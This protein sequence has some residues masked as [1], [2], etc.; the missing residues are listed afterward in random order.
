MPSLYDVNFNQQ[1]SDLLPP[2][3]RTLGVVSLMQ[4]LLQS[5]QWC[6]DLVLGSYKSGATAPNYAPGSY[7][8]YQQVVYK[9]GVYSSLIDNNTDTPDVASSWELIQS[10]FIGVDE[11]VKYNGQKIVLEYALNK[12][13]GGVFRPPASI[14]LSDIYIT[15]IPPSPF[16]FRVGL[17]IGSSVG[18]TNSSDSV[19]SLYPFIQINNFQINFPRSLYILTNENEVR[20]FVNL[21]ATAGLNYIIASY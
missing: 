7:S 8:Q 14:A 11:R 18:L 5:V 9:K 20:D 3:K 12:R 21:Y 15:L 6:R 19:G 4:A 13:F 1:A 2:D 17:T 10:N 16:G